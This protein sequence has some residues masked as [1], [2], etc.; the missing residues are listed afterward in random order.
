M[1]CIHRGKHLASGFECSS[2]RLLKLHGFVTEEICN[3][4]VCPYYNVPNRKSSGLGDTIHKFTHAL[5]IDK[6]VGDCGCG[7][8][9]AILN[10]IVPYSAEQKE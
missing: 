4:E 5:G 10:Q 9:K 7:K 3:Q 2:D 1:T 8:R 6:L